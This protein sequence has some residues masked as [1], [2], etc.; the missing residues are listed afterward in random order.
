MITEIV[1]FELPA[2][3]TRQQALEKYRETAP[4]WAA[5]P[6]LLRKTYF[7]DAEACRGGGVYVW[8]DRAAAA[9]W[10]DE[11]FRARIR[12]HYGCEPSFQILD[13]VVEVDNVAGEIREP[14]EG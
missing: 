1:S 6:D 8:K 4:V 7:F 9:R 11:A 12:E 5:N 2:G 3:T 14:P 13:A 10:H